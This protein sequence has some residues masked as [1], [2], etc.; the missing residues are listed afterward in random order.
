MIVFGLMFLSFLAGIVVGIAIMTW[1][2]R[3]DQ[4]QRRTGGFGDDQT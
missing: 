3:L 2:A 1:L 4:E